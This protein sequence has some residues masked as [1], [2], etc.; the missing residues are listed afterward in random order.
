MRGWMEGVCREDR[1]LMKGS[2]AVNL[3]QRMRCPR[4]WWECWWV[5]FRYK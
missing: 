2:R 1:A 4:E 3:V 5:D